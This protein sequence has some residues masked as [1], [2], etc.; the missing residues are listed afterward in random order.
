MASR[1]GILKVV[2]LAILLGTVALYRILFLTIIKTTEK[3]IPLVKAF[4]SRPPK[5]SNQIMANLSATPSATPLHG[6]R[7]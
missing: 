7:L 4:M 2:D 5:H 1:N 3:V 6:A